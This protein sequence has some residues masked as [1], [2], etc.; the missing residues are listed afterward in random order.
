MLRRFFF[1]VVDFILL[2]FAHIVVQPH[3]INV[4]STT[5]ID[6]HST[7]KSFVAHIDSRMGDAGGAIICTPGDAY[8]NS[9]ADDVDV[10]YLRTFGRKCDSDLGRIVRG[11]CSSPPHN[12][13]YAI[14]AAHV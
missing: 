1:L 2:H 10:T 14:V 4:D 13:G 11:A 5:A 3:P 8:V 12:D 9:V 6:A 7:T